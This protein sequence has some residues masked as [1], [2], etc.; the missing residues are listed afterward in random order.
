MTG[1]C[2]A[3]LLFEGVENYTPDKFALIR[4]TSGVELALILVEKTSYLNGSVGNSIVSYAGTTSYS[5]DRCA[6][7]HEINFVVANPK[8]RKA[9]YA[10]YCCMSKEFGYITSDRNGSSSNAAKATWAKIEQSSDWE[11]LELDNYSDDLLD[12]TR[13]YFDVRGSWPSRDF[14]ELDGPKTPP[15]NDDCEI[16]ANKKSLN[17]KLGTANAWKYV[18]SLDAASLLQAGVEMLKT[19]KTRH[20]LSIDDQQRYIFAEA[21][22]LFRFHY[23][24]DAND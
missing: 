4:H 8:F 16:P 19:Y 6:G 22:K 9:G 23:V 21:E 5:S 1:I 24:D 12:G 18:G 15:P 10:M 13:Y 7:A 17:K 3:D 2:F 11:K 20:D 14:Q